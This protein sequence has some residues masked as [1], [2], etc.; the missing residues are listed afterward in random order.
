MLAL[1]Q[2][3]DKM[4]ALN[5]NNAAMVINLVDYLS[6]MQSK[7]ADHSENPF[8]KAWEEGKNNPMTEEE[9]DEFVS[10]VRTERNDDRH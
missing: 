1:Q 3:F 5:E 10:T 8:H 6:E 2:T 4:N 7:N 9:V